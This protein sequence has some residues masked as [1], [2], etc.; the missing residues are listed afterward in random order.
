MLFDDRE[1]CFKGRK[2]FV[3]M[4]VMNVGNDKLPRLN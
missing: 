2:A 4:F 1:Q 3:E